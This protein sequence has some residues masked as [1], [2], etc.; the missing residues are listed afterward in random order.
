MTEHSELSEFLSDASALFHPEAE[1]EKTSSKRSGRITRYGGESYLAD[2]SSRDELAMRND[3]GSTSTLKVEIANRRDIPFVSYDIEEAKEYVNKIPHYV[4]RIYGHLV[5]GQKAVVTITGI[6]VFF[7]IRVP[8]NASIPKF[9]SK[10]KHLLATEKDSQGN[11]VNMNLIRREC[12]KAYPIR[13]YHAEKKSYLRIIAPNE[14]IRF[15]ALD[16]ISNYNSKVDQENRIETASDDTGTYYRKVAREY[17]IPLSGWG[18]ISDY[19]YNFSAPYYAK[20]QHCPHAFYVHIGNFQ[21]I[22]DF[23]PLY[24]I[25][26]SSLFSRDQALVLTWDIKTYDSRGL[27]NFPQAENDTAQVFMICMTVHWKDDPKPLEQIRL[28]DVETAPDPCCTTIICG[29][30]TNLLKAF[31]LCWKSFAPNIQLG[32]NDSGYDWPFIVEKATKLKVLDWMVQQ[33]SANLRKTANT[34]SILIWNY[35]GGTGKPL[36][37]G[38]F[39]RDQWAKKTDRNFRRIE[40]R[41]SINIKF[42]TNNLSFESSFLKL[43]GCVP[44]DV[45]ASLLQLFPRSER[46]SLKYF[47]E[48]CGLDSKADLPMSKLWKYYSEAKGRISDSSTENMHEIANYC[49]IDALRCQELAVRHNIINDYREVASIAYITLFDTHYYAIGTKVSNLLGAE[50]WTQDILFSMKTS[51]QKASGKFPGAYVFPPVK[52]LENKRPVTGLDFASLYPSIIMAYNLSPEKMVSTLSEADELQRE[53]KV[54]HNIEFKYNGDPIRAWTIRHGNK[55]DQKGLFPKILE[56]LGRIRN[57]IK[58]QLKLLWKKKECIEL[59][60]GRMDPASESTPIA[61]VIKDILSS[62]K[63]TKKRSEVAQTLDPFIDLSYDIFIKEYSSIYF[64]YDSLN[65]KQKAIKLY[66]NSFYGVTGRS[67]SPFYILELAGGVTLAGREHIKCV[68]EYVKGKGF[69]IKYGDTDSLYLTCPDSYYEKCDLA[70]NDGEGTISKLEYWTEMVN[71]TMDTMEKLR[72]KVNTFLRL[73]TRSDYLKMAYEEV[74]FPVAFTGKKKY[75]GIDHEETPNFEPREPFIRGI[76]TVKQGKSQVF[77][78]IGDRI[79][80][81]AMDINN[82]QSLHEIVED[83]LRD[84]IINHEQWN[85]E[86]FIETD[87]WKPDKDNKPVQRFIGRMKGKYDTKIPVP[88]GRFSYVVTHPDTTFDL[89]GRKLD[90][91]KGEKMEFVDVA[92]EL[93]MSRPPRIK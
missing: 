59:V 33:M 43:P 76:D 34:Q 78:T 22:V 61:S 4:L 74:L 40:G 58:A 36:S 66:M 26:P 85:F 57:E 68:A 1:K 32:F 38:F 81:R 18:L 17:R 86:Q 45:C 54:L 60:K 25:Y 3:E 12:I 64:T 72:N 56:R 28:V 31:A 8:E 79:M 13:S 55:S 53:N 84:A 50:A 24:K 27:G 77:K 62:I 82:V 48:D 20:S 80:R 89:H 87:A 65:S 41:E 21:P 46:R 49:T 19:K 35:F 70:Y 10:I 14:D 39:H 23:E 92:K 44:I 30:Q 90:P 15:T 52:G 69:G 6:K 91:T 71:I 75:F 16:I 37:S 5:N 63:D 47:L 73:K 42:G 11:R 29:N 88:G 67:D 83:V 51:D 93:D 9:W 7:D 2:I